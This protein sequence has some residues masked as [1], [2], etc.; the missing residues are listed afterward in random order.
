MSIPSRVDYCVQRLQRLW[1]SNPAPGTEQIS[2]FNM[3]NNSTNEVPTLGQ[4]FDPYSI[5]KARIP[6]AIVHE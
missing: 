6:Q 2:I 3:P 4:H 5:P 1:S